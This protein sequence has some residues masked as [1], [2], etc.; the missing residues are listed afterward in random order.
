MPSIRKETHHAGILS[1]GELRIVGV[2]VL[3]IDLAAS[4]GHGIG[5]EGTA[6]DDGEQTLGKR[7]KGRCPRNPTGEHLFVVPIRVSDQFAIRVCTESIGLL[8]TLACAV[9]QCNQ[10]VGRVWGRL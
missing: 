3:L 10:R 4:S 1:I 9:P 8:S 7:S 2:G 6:L 5:E